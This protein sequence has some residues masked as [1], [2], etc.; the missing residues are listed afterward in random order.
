MAGQPLELLAAWT[1]EQDFGS[2][3]R[4]Q[5]PVA[6]PDQGHHPDR[7]PN[8]AAYD[9]GERVGPY[10]GH[11]CRTSGATEASFSARCPAQC[12]TLPLPSGSGESISA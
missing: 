9:Q 11:G 12:L 7:A 8:S 2:A 1:A 10:W 6:R 3:E 5:G 4:Q